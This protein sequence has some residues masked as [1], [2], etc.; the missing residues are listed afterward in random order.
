MMS[1]AYDDGDSYVGSYTATVGQ[2]AHVA[3]TA[4]QKPATPRTRG[5]NR[6]VQWSRD[7]Y[8]TNHHFYIPVMERR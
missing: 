7:G 6:A 5:A 1:T 8:T 4:I 2:V 3:A